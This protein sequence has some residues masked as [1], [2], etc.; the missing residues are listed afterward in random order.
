M[1]ENMEV[2]R[3]R[4]LIDDT[5]DSIL[6][7]IELRLSL[8]KDIAAAKANSHG[9][10]LRPT[11][12]VEILERMNAQAHLASSQLIEIVW[13]E[14]IGQGRQAQG[15]MRLVLFTAGN[16]ALL[17]ECARRH[18]SSA[19]SVDWVDSR[20]MAFMS[21]QNDAVIAVVDE[22][23]DTPTLVALGEI[24]SCAGQVVGYAYA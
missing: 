8:A 6:K 2:R 13:R 18:F 11:R 21:A 15:H 24:R 7:L 4:K 20:E 22:R 19:I 10:P 12:E 9:S 5:D 16:A 23:V 17:E 3:I 14:L 1:H